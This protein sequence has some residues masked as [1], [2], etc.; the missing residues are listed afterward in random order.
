ML[1]P[2]TRATRRYWLGLPGLLIAL[3]LV[4]AACG[5]DNVDDDAAATGN[6]SPTP[7]P[8]ATPTPT[9]TPGIEAQ[10]FQALESYRYEVMMVLAG[11]VFGDELPEG[12]DLGDAEMELAV[13]GVRVSPDREYTHTVA[14]LGFLSFTIEAITIGDEQWT[15]ES[16]RGWVQS[17]ATLPGGIPG[18]VDIRPGNVFGEDWSEEDVERLQTLFE[19]HPYEVETVNDLE[20]RHYT[21][22]AEEFAA[23]F[24]GEEPLPAPADDFELTFDLWVSEDHGVPVR[25]VM[26]ALA[27]DGAEAIRLTLD[28]TDVNDPS[29][30]VEAPDT[31]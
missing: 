18:D 17:S 20:T 28:V 15:R 7:T 30:S 9:P 26:V 10:T 8:T 13:S 3:A 6:P 31:E 21:F 14:S 4:A 29:L 25:L 1:D 16:G 23:L 2:T 22:T 27:E 24:E 5:D 11:D 12:L 19:T